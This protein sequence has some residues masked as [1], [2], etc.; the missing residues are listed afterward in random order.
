MPFIFVAFPL[1]FLFFFGE[2]REALGKVDGGMVHF[3][4]WIR[5]TR[6]V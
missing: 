4:A 3:F 5:D 6:M 1:F 2:G